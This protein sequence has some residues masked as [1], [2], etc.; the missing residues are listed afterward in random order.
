MSTKTKKFQE[1]L[2][3]LDPGRTYY[4]D[5][6]GF[7]ERH[8][9]SKGWSL[10]GKRLGGKKKGQRGPRY[11]VIGLRNDEHKLLYPSLSLGTFKK[12]DFESYLLKVIPKLPKG[13]SIILD[14]ASIDK[15]LSL[16]EFLI[17]F[18]CTLVYLPPYSPELN[19]IERIWGSLKTKLRNSLASFPEDFLSALWQTIESFCSPGMI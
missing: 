3:K 9:S 11:S 6:S 13:S 19:P 7:D 10:K 16:S 8:I 5:E 1:N 18:Q 17:Q 14:N 4:L 12:L 2:K 15:N